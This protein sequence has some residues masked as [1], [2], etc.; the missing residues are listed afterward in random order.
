LLGLATYIS[1]Q[2]TKEIGIRKV[3]GSSQAHIIGKLTFNL[4]K[5]VF[6]AFVIASPL[7]WMYLK[8]WLANFAYHIELDVWIFT[9]AAVLALGVGFL[10][11]ILQAY[12]A[13]RTNPVNSLRYE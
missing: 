7:A 4:L 12:R 10:S 9:L 3:F 11:V 5:W 6:L 1:L 2:R 13:S 8:R